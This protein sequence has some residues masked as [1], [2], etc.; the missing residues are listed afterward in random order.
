MSS[1]VLY[2]VHLVVDI[3][4]SSTKSAVMSD[5]RVLSVCREECLGNGLSELVS[6]AKIS[7]GICSS[8]RELTDGERILLSSLP[9]PVIHLSAQTPL[10]LRIVYSTPGTLGPDRIASAVGAWKRMP[11][12]N[13]LIIDAGTAV[14]YDVV[15]AEGEYLGGNISP[16]LSMR[17]R[18]LH[19]FTGRL[20]L[21]SPD[22]DVPDVG[23]STETAI[24][25]GVVLGMR[26][27]MLGCISRLSAGY[28]S[29]F[30]FLT[31]GDAEL[32]GIPI[33]NGIF[34]DEFL[35]LEGL[36]TICSFNEKM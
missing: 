9:F 11:G 12:R 36:D 23:Y 3:G 14:T 2:M 21:V 25:S 35:L 4:N 10:P 15:T 13:L 18:A 19:E 8:V 32:F 1:K 6:D 5:G 31:G 7:C 17:L 27:E 16:G 28:D 22:G 33:K 30:V 24:R 26:D 20:P 29:I 34:A